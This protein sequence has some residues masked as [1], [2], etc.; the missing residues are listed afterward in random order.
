MCSDMPSSSGIVCIA[1]I[2]RS[3]RRLFIAN[4]IIDSCKQDIGLS[5][6]V[7]A[8]MMRQ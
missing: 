4:S 7:V 8:Y 1:E 3:L 5:L 2:R 6:E